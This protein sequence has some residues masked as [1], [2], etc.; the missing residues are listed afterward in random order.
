[1]PGVL[2]FDVVECLCGLEDIHQA[3]ARSRPVHHPPTP[4]L[5]RSHFYVLENCLMDHLETVAEGINHYVMAY[6]L[7]RAV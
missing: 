5:P 2:C 7:L 1:M 6:L 3:A 4:T